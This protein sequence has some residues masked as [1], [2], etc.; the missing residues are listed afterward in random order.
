MGLLHEALRCRK[1]RTIRERRLQQLGAAQRHEPRPRDVLLRVPD[2]LRL[3]R[4]FAHRERRCGRARFPP[5]GQLQASV[6][7]NFAEGVLAALA[8]I[9]F[10]VVHGLRLHSA[11]RQQVRRAPPCIQPVRHFPPQRNMA[12]RELDVHRLGR[13]SRYFPRCNRP[14]ASR[15]IR[16]KIGRPR[17][18]IASYWMARHIR[19]CPLRLDILPRRRRNRGIRHNRKDLYAA[20]TPFPGRRRSKPGARH[21]LHPCLWRAS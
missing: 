5:N 14:L 11:R 10:D 1:S 6:P 21:P 16:R 15:Q 17:V 13:D 18:G 3:L 8:H 7:R 9:A 4:L 19:G 20:G 2:I 12:R